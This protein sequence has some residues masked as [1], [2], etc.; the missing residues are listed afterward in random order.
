[1]HKRKAA[2][3]FDRLPLRVSRQRNITKYNS[4]ESSIWGAGGQLM[5][6]DMTGN[7][8]EKFGTK[9]CSSYLDSTSRGDI[10]GIRL[11]QIG[12]NKDN[13][14]YAVTNGK[15]RGNET[16]FDAFGEIQGLVDD[17]IILFIDAKGVLG[18]ASRRRMCDL[19][20]KPVVIKINTLGH[21][22]VAVYFPEVATLE[23]FDPSGFQG[24]VAMM[25]TKHLAG[26]VKKRWEIQRKPIVRVFGLGQPI[27]ISKEDLY[28]QTWIW[29]WVY[30]RVIEGCDGNTI[31]KYLV[32]LNEK[33]RV[34]EIKVFLNE[35]I[36]NPNEKV[37]GHVCTNVPESRAVKRKKN[38]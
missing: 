22:F 8:L 32:T 24:P 15:I 29:W 5:C 14:R 34:E 26:I 16:W 30:R 33:E 10:A 12:L 27:Q 9:V 21:I 13:F 38:I 37:S 18:S 7:F 36:F 35:I 19:K 17:E 3:K 23:I 6:A 28:C 2:E 11:E 20:R 31:Q 25:F 1:M 4:D